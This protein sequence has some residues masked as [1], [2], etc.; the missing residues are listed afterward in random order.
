MC[1]CRTVQDGERADELS[2]CQEKME[3]LRRQLVREKHLTARLHRAASAHVDTPLV[4]CAFTHYVPVIHI[5]TGHT[6]LTT[7]SSTNQHRFI[8]KAAVETELTVVMGVPSATLSWLPFKLFSRKKIHL[9]GTYIDT[10]NNSFKLVR[11]GDR[12]CR[13]ESPV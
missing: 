5:H 2:R 7:I 4:Y 12:Y 13:L 8:W 3:T 6:A 11:S 1:D 10:T 9:V